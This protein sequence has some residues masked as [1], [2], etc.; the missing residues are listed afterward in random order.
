[1]EEKY[2]T[3]LNITKNNK[4]AQPTS[5]AWMRVTEKETSK[6]GCRIRI[7]VGCEGDKMFATNISPV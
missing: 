2:Q 4:T 5:K 6:A 7:S 1:M 3:C